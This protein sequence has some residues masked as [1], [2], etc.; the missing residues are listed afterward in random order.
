MLNI[1]Q[2]NR[3]LQIHESD[4]KK[5]TVTKMQV[6]EKIGFDESST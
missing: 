1:A 5:T 4:K 2:V 6:L 3:I